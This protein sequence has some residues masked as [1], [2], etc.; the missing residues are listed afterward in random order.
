MVLD[1]AD[2]LAAL[3]YP[4][5]ESQ[6]PAKAFRDR[7]GPAS[8]TRSRYPFAT[9]ND[10]GKGKAVY[11]AGSIFDI[12]WQTNHSWLR[13]FMEAVLRY[14]DP[15]MP[16]DVEASGK[17]EAN[18]MRLGGDLLL[19]LIHYSLGHQG[20]QSAIAAV[21]KV[22]P[23]HDIPCRVRCSHVERVVLEPQAEEIPFTFEEGIC[24]FTV[25]EIEYLAM[26]RLV[27]ADAE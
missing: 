3:H 17:I 5:A 6:P 2:E 23:V 12:Y 10:Y 8:Y 25:P 4:M 24:S 26:I 7:N 27:A 1:G 22:E 16:Y 14:V 21:E 20:G 19:N 9:V 18:L 11:I 15:S 13:Q